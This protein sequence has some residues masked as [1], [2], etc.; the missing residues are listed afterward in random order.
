MSNM[1]QQI[2]IMVANGLDQVQ[3]LKDSD[4]MGKARKLY[5]QIVQPLREM[6][7]RVIANNLQGVAIELNRLSDLLEK[8]Q[9]ELSDDVDAAFL[10]NIQK[11]SNEVQK[12]RAEIGTDL[13]FGRAE[14]AEA[15]TEE[16]DGV[17]DTLVVQAVI[18]IPSPRDSLPQSKAEYA[19]AF[20]DL[21]IRNKWIIRAD[22]VVD[23]IIGQN[24]VK[25]YREVEQR[26]TVPWWF[27]G[28]LHS[29]EASCDFD[30]HI[31][32]GDPL[33]AQTVNVPAGRPPVWSESMT[34]ESSAVDALAEVKNLDEVTDWSLGTILRMMERWNGLGYRK[35]GVFSPFLW[36]GSTFYEKGKYVRD[37][38]F[39]AEKISEQCGVA[40]VI[41]R[42]EERKVIGIS[43]ASKKV[44]PRTAALVGSVSLADINT[45]PFKHANVEL[46]FP[47]LIKMGMGGSSDTRKNIDAVRRVQEWCCYHGMRTGIDGDFSD[48]TLRVVKRF[49]AKMFLEQTGI[50]D[51]E[52]WTLLTLPI[53]EALETKTPRLTLNKTVIQVAQDHIKK[54]PIEIGGNNH[55]PWVRLYMSGKDGEEQLWCAGFVSF[56]VAQSS[57]NMGIDM[58]F[59]RQVGVDA[60]VNDAKR[61]GRFISE[62]SLNVPLL[63]PTRIPPGSLFVIRNSKNSNDWTHTGIVTG[64]NENDFDTI[65]GNTN[66]SN[67]DGSNAKISNRGYRFKDFILLT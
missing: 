34:W 32:N 45:S 39:D 30:K 12:A 13:R 36:S 46:N 23:R 5:D 26:T 7:L 62:E 22:N 41:K 47:K 56:I 4:E 9:K 55:G 27:V 50:V 61:S 52:T 18:K 40:V 29:M 53:R 57:R 20:K 43:G 65:E 48:S 49:Q 8:A 31:H 24:S 6:R 1:I 28:I 35:H 42:M 17:K 21:K 16:T 59:K 37:G 10:N 25:R 60:L 44:K 54:R 11:S 63:R 15:A 2:D 33:N 66:G 38:M 64:A 58:P 51:E 67:R 14:E 3:R 19:K